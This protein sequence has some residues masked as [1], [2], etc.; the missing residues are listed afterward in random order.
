M[1]SVLLYFFLLTPDS[2]PDTTAA[3]IGSPSEPPIMLSLLEDEKLLDD[4]MVDVLVD[5]LVEVKV[6]VEVWV[7]VN[8]MAGVGA[9]VTVRVGDGVEMGLP[10]GES[11]TGM[12]VGASLLSSSSGQGQ[13][14][15]FFFFFFLFLFLRLLRSS[16]FLIC[17]MVRSSE[18]SCESVKS[19]WGSC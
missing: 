7:E 11:V 10:V 16:I 2:C 19:K 3:T 4:V 12:L 6:E 9:S 1:T 15:R 8:V 5:V 18:S 13:G 14:F 17:S